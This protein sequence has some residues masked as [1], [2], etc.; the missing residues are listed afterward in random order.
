M[1]AIGAVLVSAAVLVPLAG[2]A[3]AASSSDTSR[4]ET[5]PMVRPS[6]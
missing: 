3:F 5:R 4:P 1:G 6:R 2:T